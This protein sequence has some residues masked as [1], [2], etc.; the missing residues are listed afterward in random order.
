MELE[1]EIENST[2]T[3]ED[4]N[5]PLSTIINRTTRQKISEDIEE[6]NTTS[7]LQDLI[8]IYRIL[9]P[10]LVECTLFS[11]AC[12][13]YIK[14]DYTLGYKTNLNKFKIIEV[15]HSIFSDHNE[16]KLEMNNRKQMETKQ[17]TLS[18]L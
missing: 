3:L 5:T 14:I 18:N 16:I 17:H 12:G 1:R 6:I 15:I 11:S 7:N 10:T 8:Y 2:V 13:T 9:H 4:V